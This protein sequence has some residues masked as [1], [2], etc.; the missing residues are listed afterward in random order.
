[1][2]WLNPHLLRKVRTREDLNKV[3]TEQSHLLQTS[4]QSLIELHT[5]CTDLFTHKHTK[6]VEQVVVIKINT[7][8]HYYD[9]VLSSYYS[10]M[11]LSFAYIRFILFCNPIFIQMKFKRKTVFNKFYFQIF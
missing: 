10:G 1:M 2:Q 7:I 5:Y 4:I 9:I 6:K 11:V 8:L 3:A